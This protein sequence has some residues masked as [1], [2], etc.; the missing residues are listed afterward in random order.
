MVAKRRPSSL[1]S[2][3]CIL[4][5]MTLFSSME[6]GNDLFSFFFFGVCV[7]VGGGGGGID[8]TFKVITL[9][10]GVH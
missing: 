8:P 1:R 4:V 9:C 5:T 7:C 10:E 6:E 2:Y 3:A